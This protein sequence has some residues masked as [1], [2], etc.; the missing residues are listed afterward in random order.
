MLLSKV[1]L[2]IPSHMKQVDTPCV[3]NGQ[4]YD[5]WSGLSHNYFDVAGYPTWRSEVRVRSLTDTSQAP[6]QLTGRSLAYH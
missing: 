6:A 1:I 3:E 4:L 5:V 2:L